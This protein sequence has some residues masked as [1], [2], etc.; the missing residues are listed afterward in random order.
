[1][2]QQ[3]AG[4]FFGERLGLIAVRRIAAVG[5]TTQRCLRSKDFDAYNLLECPVLVL[6]ALRC[7]N[8]SGLRHMETG[9]LQSLSSVCAEHGTDWAQLQEKMVREGRFHVGTY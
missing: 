3:K 1:M 8:W 6:L 7:E 2:M 5:N 9:V 4:R